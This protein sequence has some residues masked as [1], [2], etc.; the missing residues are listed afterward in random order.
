[1]T[2]PCVKLA[3]VDD[4]IEIRKLLKAYLAQQGFSVVAFVD[5]ESLLADC[6]DDYSLC[7]LDIIARY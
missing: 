3:L 5:G 1:M 4:D 7:I 6:V 2:A